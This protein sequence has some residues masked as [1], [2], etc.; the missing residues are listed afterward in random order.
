MLSN[1]LTEDDS[2]VGLLRKQ[3]V[4]ILTREVDSSPKLE[5]IQLSV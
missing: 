3:V 1:K 2:V 4:F 5:L